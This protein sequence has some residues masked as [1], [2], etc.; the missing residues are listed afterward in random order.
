MTPSEAPL[1]FDRLASVA[2]MQEQAR[3]SLINY[4]GSAGS[5]Q[6]S[7]EVQMKSVDPVS[8]EPGCQP[9]GEGVD[10]FQSPCKMQYDAD[11][12]RPNPLEACAKRRCNGD[13]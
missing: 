11:A 5:F 6:V 12:W 4:R 8:N 1:G 2:A 9:G 3:N 7:A 13:V 10:R